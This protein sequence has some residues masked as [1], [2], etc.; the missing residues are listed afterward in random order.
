MLIPCNYL[1]LDTLKSIY[2]ILWG[3]PM[4]ILL[5]GVQLFVTFKLKFVQKHTF[6]SLKLTFSSDKTSSTS[7]FAT[8]TT[9]LA[10]TLGTGNIIGVSTDVALGGP[11]A[12]FWCWLTGLLG[13]ATSYAECYLSFLYRIPTS[14]TTSNTSSKCTL[15]ETQLVNNTTTSTSST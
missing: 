3:A 7:S 8:L 11:G 13:M 14:T 1:V 4:I 2:N 15:P 9:A 10:A 6:K 5:L 12:I